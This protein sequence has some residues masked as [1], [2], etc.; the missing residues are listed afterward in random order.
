MIFV[1]PSAATSTSFSWPKIMMRLSRPDIRL[2]GVDRPDDSPGQLRLEVAANYTLFSPAVGPS[3]D[4]F[5]N[6]RSC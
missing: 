6:G 3:Q 2:R 5:R 1:Q 4:C